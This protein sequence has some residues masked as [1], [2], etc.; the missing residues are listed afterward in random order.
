MMQETQ[1]RYSAPVLTI[2]CET[3]PEFLSGGMGTPQM[4]R[5]ER[6]ARSSP[7]AP[8][9]ALDVPLRPSSKPHV[10][11]AMCTQQ[12]WDASFL[13]SRIPGH[14]DLWFSYHLEV[15]GI[16]QIYLYDLDGSFADLEVVA[17]WRAAGRIIYEDAFGEIQPLK[18][19][20]ED[21]GL[22]TGS[23]HLTQTLVQHHCLQQA[24]TNADWI[25]SVSHGWD[26]ML[27][28]PTQTLN[29][30]LDSLPEDALT[31]IPA[32]RYG[33]KEET[34]AGNT[35]GNVFSRFPHRND[36][37]LPMDTMGI[38]E[39]RIL[40]GSPRL[41]DGLLLSDA[42]TRLGSQLYSSLRQGLGFSERAQW[43]PHIVDPVLWR[44]NHYVELLGRKLVYLRE[45]IFPELRAF[46][47]FDEAAYAL[48][49]WFNGLMKT[50]ID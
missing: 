4:V 48:G 29:E 10:R 42:V 14:L 9:I 26:M 2:R 31:F 36:L 47:E 5:L 19:V 33:T 30:L 3:P 32:V 28:S 46:S 41:L 22:N 44:A 15:L 40:I 38:P 8:W 37:N 49:E 50:S 20:F 11:T 16:D 43:N 17:Y 6:S 23:A 35:G 13:E 39:E 25:V 27:F 21:L 12:T 34:P 24:K 7:A 1:G 45:T 18:R